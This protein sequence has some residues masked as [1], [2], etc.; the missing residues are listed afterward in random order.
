MKNCGSRLS[1]F[2]SYILTR[3]R[4]FCDVRLGVGL[5]VVFHALWYTYIVS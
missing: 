4:R 2:I 1:S 5:Y 3:V